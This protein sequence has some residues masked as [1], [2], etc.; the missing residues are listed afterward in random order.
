MAFRNSGGRE[1]AIILLRAPGSLDLVLK[2]V[3]TLKRKQCPQFIWNIGT[4][5]MM[6]SPRHG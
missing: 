1:Q 5:I 3:R 6:F 4:K 2:S